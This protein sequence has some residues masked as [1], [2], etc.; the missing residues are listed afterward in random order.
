MAKLTLQ[1]ITSGYQTQNVY[2]ENNS[3]IE[4]ALE[5]TLSR[6]GTGPNAMAAPLDMNSRDINNC[7]D[8]YALASTLR[9][10][11][12][13]LNGSV[14]AV[15]NALTLAPDAGSISFTP[16]NPVGPVTTVQD[17]LD[18][19]YL[20]NDRD[21]SPVGNWAFTGT[22]GVSGL[23]SADG[24]LAITGN[25]TTDGL[26]DGVDIAAR[27]TDLANLETDVLALESDFEG[28]TPFT[29]TLTAATS[30]S[31][32]LNSALDELS[33]YRIGRIVFVQGLIRINS[34]SA[35]V[36]EIRLNG[37]PYT[38]SNLSESSNNNRFAVTY[39]NLNAAIGSGFMGGGRIF[40]GSNQIVLYETDGQ[41]ETSIAAKL[42]AATDI[43]F[44]F[45]YLVD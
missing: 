10:K 25:T 21:E 3:L 39:E 2:N 14:I 20:R 22:L 26:I 6:D 35:P 44:G 33:Y 42:Q 5:N 28:P 23:L 37:L 36:G 19:D 13:I 32:L 29:V 7:G 15:S 11:S 27:D 1:D 24:G 30:G 34:V 9:V 8:I 31:V 43:A 4:A 12:F 17:A 40:E 16:S 41:A 45:H 38:S 18:D